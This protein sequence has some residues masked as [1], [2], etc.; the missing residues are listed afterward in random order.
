MQTFSTVV[1]NLWVATFMLQFVTVA[2]LHTVKRWKRKEL[3]GGEGSHNTRS[4]I[5]G[6]LGTAALDLFFLLNKGRACHSDGAKGKRKNLA[7]LLLNLPPATGSVV[8]A[9]ALSDFVKCFQITQ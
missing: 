1:L 5:R 7:L 2:K 9:A 8:E 4:C 3:Y 6:R